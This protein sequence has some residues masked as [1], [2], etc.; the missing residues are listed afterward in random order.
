M[1]DIDSITTAFKNLGNEISYKKI[2]E[3]TDNQ[4]KE[5]KILLANLEKVNSTKQSSSEKGT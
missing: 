3:F 1:N 2:C 5:Y 4:R